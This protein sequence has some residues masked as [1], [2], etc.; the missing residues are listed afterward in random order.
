MQATGVGAPQSGSGSDPHREHFNVVE[1]KRR[2]GRLPALSSCG[3]LDPRDAATRNEHA[4][5][6]GHERLHRASFSWIEPGSGGSFQAAS[7]AAPM[8]K[9]GVLLIYAAPCRGRVRA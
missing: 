7:A 1:R 8:W 5:A 9:R 4:L 6:D 2:E 3:V